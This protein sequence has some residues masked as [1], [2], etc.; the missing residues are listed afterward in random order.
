MF[1]QIEQ[2]RLNYHRTHQVD[3]KAANY[4]AVQDYIAGDTDVPG[5]RIVLPSSF[6][7]SPRAMVQNFQDAMAIVSKF[8]KPD[9]FLTFTCNPAWT[10]ISENLG[11]RQSASDRPDLIARVFKLKVS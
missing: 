5:R 6:P 3:L 8:G 11:P 2:N 10:E 1:L 9:I 7:G 4:N